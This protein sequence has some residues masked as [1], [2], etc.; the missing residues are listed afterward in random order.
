M[1]VGDSGGMYCWGKDVLKAREE[2]GLRNRKRHDRQ[3]E[4]GMASM[5][6]S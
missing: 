1:N 4:L 6:S 3:I 5:L 2:V